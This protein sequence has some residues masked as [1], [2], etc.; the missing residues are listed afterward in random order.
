MNCSRGD[1]RDGRPPPPE[2]PDP[3]TFRILP[4]NLADPA[5]FDA[6]EGDESGRDRQA[7]LPNAEMA[8]HRAISGI[9]V[10]VTA[11]HLLAT[12]PLAVND[13]RN[14]RLAAI[15]LTAAHVALT[16]LPAVVS[17]TCHP[18][19][20]RRVMRVITNSVWPVTGLAI[21]AAFRGTSSPLELAFVGSGVTSVL[22]VANGSRNSAFLYS[23]SLSSV[24]GIAYYL[25]SEESG[26]ETLSSLLL[27]PFA[28]TAPFLQLA[29]A[30][31]EHGREHD[32][33]ARRT[34]ASSVVAARL[35]TASA[36]ATRFN[37]LLHDQVLA[38]LKAVKAGAPP[39]MVIRA[40]KVALKLT[41]PTS[42]N[43][44][45]SW[46]HGERA[47]FAGVRGDARTG[48]V[49]GSALAASLH[50][51]VRAETPDCAIH[52]SVADLAIPAEVA[53]AMVAA[54]RQVARNSDRH[55]GPSVKRSCEINIAEEGV[56]VRFTD[57]GCGFEPA[58]V[59][60]DRMGL[61]TSI[62]DRLH[63][64]E[65]ASAR[66]VSASGQGTTIELEW[67]PTPIGAAEFEAADGAIRDTAISVLIGVL[68]SLQALAEP[69]SRRNPGSSVL[70][71][72][73]LMAAVGIQRTSPRGRP[74]LA[75]AAAIIALALGGTIIP[76]V[77][78]VRTAAT[79]VP[80]W[81]EYAFGLTLGL[82][83][84]RGRPAPAIGTAA[85]WFAAT[86]ALRLRA[87][88]PVDIQA[89][90][91]APIFVFTGVMARRAVEDVVRRVEEARAAERR[92]LDSIGRRHAE[93]KVREANRGWL[94]D[95][96]GGFLRRIRGLA[97]ARFGASDRAHA[98]L[99][100]ARIRDALRSPRLDRP[101][102][103]RVAWDL[104]TRGV[105]VL[106][107]DDR[108]AAPSPEGQL[109]AVAEAFGDLAPDVTGGRVT[110]RILPAG[111]ADFATI[112]VAD[113]GAD[114]LRIRIPAV[115]SA[116]RGT[117]GAPDDAAS[118]GGGSAAWG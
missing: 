15:P 17:R 89:S 20:F 24:I 94:D 30:G 52:I 93:Q 72:G 46:K 44:R 77:A 12:M 91:L 56:D 40:A 116:D 78:G 42:V 31:V 50:S 99:L 34:A 13:I 35:A 101:D 75:R 66:V 11:T 58:A 69:S 102:I 3:R 97:G 25:N 43:S 54:L 114:P 82:V 83:A 16:T 107:V 112:V 23:A 33:I 67:T 98:G 47:P 118:D 53:S 105:T 61:R 79:G 76:G 95:V 18:D 4:G 70:G 106:L 96:A 90:A 55:A 1:D 5:I 115:S 68:V 39:D 21:V 60:E 103:S 63:S 117:P 36:E 37:A 71:W 14:G 32:A 7:P 45:S 113:G 2:D 29:R 22:S 62:L 80:P 59:P 28:V 6:V 86:T 74:S 92:L 88:R 85:A 81:H 100:D 73:L 27:M 64:L 87:G 49:T 110:V 48:D 109:D 57:D 104:R 9:I 111:R 51:V 41:E 65:G 108:G 38:V 19:T 84:A 26:V 8:A 10:P